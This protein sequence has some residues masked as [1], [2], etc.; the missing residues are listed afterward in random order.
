[1]IDQLDQDTQRKIEGMLLAGERVALPFNNQEL[2]PGKG[3]VFGLGILNTDP[4]KTN[5]YINLEAGPATKPDGSEIAPGENKFREKSPWLLTAEQEIG[6][7]QQKTITI[8]VAVP[9][10]TQMGTYV[11]NVYV[12]SDAKELISCSS[13]SNKLYDVVQKIYITVP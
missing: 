6:N 13:N 7:D 12:C 10:G 11:I 5:F 3:H 2:H 1:M 9:R 8:M 4:D